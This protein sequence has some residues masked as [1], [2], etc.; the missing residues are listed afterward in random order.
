MCKGDLQWTNN[1]IDLLVFTLF[2]GHR[3]VCMSRG[4]GKLL[5]AYIQIFGFSLLKIHGAS[6]F[7]GNDRNGNGNMERILRVQ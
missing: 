5:S 6:E 2:Q 1:V 3:Q 4:A 7:C